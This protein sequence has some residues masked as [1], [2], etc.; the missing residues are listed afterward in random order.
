MEHELISKNNSHDCK[1]KIQECNDT[2]DAKPKPQEHVDLLVDD[3][4][5]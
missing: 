5:G 4:D 2:Q 1:A 3:I